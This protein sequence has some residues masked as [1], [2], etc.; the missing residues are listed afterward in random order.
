MFED[1]QRPVGNC[2]GMDVNIFFPTVESEERAV[3]DR[4]CANCPARAECLEY[5]FSFEVGGGFQMPGVWGNTSTEER[6][7][8]RKARKLAA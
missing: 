2:E 4:Y 6:R 7:A 3:A 5:A 1:R 8:I